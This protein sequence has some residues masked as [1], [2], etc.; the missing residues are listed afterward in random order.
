MDTKENLSAAF[1]N[2]GQAMSGCCDAAVDPVDAPCA[3]LAGRRMQIA[4]RVQDWNAL[5]PESDDYD[6]V[7]AALENSAE[8]LTAAGS[9]QACLN[10]IGAANQALN[11][12]VGL[13]DGVH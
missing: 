2:Q 3:G 5:P 7:I 10:A 12:L 11:G 4:N 9:D 13:L 8:Q 1:Q 6:E